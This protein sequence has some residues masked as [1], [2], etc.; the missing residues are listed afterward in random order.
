MTKVTHCPICGKRYG[1]ID[2][3]SNSA[4]CPACFKAKN[5]TGTFGTRKEEAL[6]P[7]ATLG[8]IVAVLCAGGA[9]VVMLIP[10]REGASPSGKFYLVGLAVAGIAWGLRQIAAAKAEKK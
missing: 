9:V 10:A 8:K 2:R 7:D 6:A 1:F 4:M 5:K 3:F